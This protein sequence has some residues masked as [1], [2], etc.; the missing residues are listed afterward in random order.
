[1]DT[2]TGVDATVSDRV[3]AWIA[4]SKFEGAEGFDA[5]RGPG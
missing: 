2:G 4:T 3:Q 1:M 5:G